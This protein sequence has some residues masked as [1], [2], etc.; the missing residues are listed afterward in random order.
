[1]AGI[2]VGVLVVAGVTT[3]GLARRSAEQTAIH[4]LED[5]APAVRD[6]LVRLVQR[7]AHA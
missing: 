1:M 7:G 3:I 6:Q 4:H 5:Q 2:S